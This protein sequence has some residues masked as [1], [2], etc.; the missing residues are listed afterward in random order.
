MKNESKA[1][2]L[3]VGF[4]PDFEFITVGTNIGFRIYNTVPFKLFIERSISKILLFKI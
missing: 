4:N 3:F 2:I 1:K